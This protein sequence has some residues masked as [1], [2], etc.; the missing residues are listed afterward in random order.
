MSLYSYPQKEPRDDPQKDTQQSTSASVEQAV[1]EACRPIESRN[2][3][4]FVAG[5]D[6]KLAELETQYESFVTKVSVKKTL[7][8]R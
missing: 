3:G 5:L 6:A 1:A 2:L 8:R 7:R 4:T